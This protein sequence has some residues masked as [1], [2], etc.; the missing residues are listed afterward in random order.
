MPTAPEQMRCACCGQ[1][2]RTGQT[3]FEVYGEP[4]CQVCWNDLDLYRPTQSFAF[5]K[6]QVTQK[7]CTGAKQKIRL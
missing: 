4:F 5:S 3:Y 1:T 2:I 6:N 7:D